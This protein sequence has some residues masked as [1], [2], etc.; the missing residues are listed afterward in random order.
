MSQ[1]RVV[2]NGAGRPT[3]KVGEEKPKIKRAVPGLLSKSG[4]DST[5]YAGRS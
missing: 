4:G 1:D 2:E 5:G 3:G